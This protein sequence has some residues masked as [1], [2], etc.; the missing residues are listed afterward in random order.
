MREAL[1]IRAA[2][3]S[4]HVAARRGFRKSLAE[5]R[6]HS[7][8]PQRALR[9]VDEQLIGVIT[10]NEVCQAVTIGFL[11]GGGGTRTQAVGSTTVSIASEAPRATSAAQRAAGLALDIA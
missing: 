1:P 4:K 5:P 9:S 6:L 8:S 3:N 11:R 2:P 10:H 7:G